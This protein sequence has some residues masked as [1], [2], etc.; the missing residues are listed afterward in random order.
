MIP[1]YGS[2]RLKEETVASATAITVNADL[3]RISGSTQ[4]ETINSPLFFNRDAR[5]IF[6]VPIDGNVALGTSGN[7]VV[8]QTLVEDRIYCL[9]WSSTE[10]KWYIHGVA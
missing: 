9:I 7:I 5:L 4:I 8:G 1:G 3:V 10:G 6:V 2:S